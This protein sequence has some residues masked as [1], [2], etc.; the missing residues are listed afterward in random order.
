[1]YLVNSIR[2]KLVIHNLHFRFMFE[3]VICNKV[4]S[5]KANNRRPWK[6]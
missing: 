5:A 3:Y 1:M 2:F 4:L 6:I